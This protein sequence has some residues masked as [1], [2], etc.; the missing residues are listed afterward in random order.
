MW[1]TEKSYIKALSISLI[2][3]FFLFGLLLIEAKQEAAIYSQAKT[4]KKTTL[5]VNEHNKL[6]TKE[7]LVQATTIDN[8]ELSEA[9]T[10]LKEE[11]ANNEKQKQLKQALLEKQAAFARKLRET[12]QKNLKK[13]KME[14][15]KLALAQKKRLIDEKKHLQDL[16]LRKKQEEQKLKKLEEKQQQKILELER[17]AAK[18][19]EDQ[20]HAKRLAQLEMKQAKLKQEALENAKIAT[21]IEK[22][23]ALI[24]DAISRQWILPE[25]IDHDAKSLFRIRLAEDG[26][27]LEVSLLK[28][29]GDPIL[30]R[31][32]QNAIH[33]ASPLPVPQDP[34]M[35]NIFRDIKLTVNPRNVRV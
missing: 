4:Q 29:S 31:S 7:E 33:K 32:A 27:V 5:V 13:L 8:K 26:L 15:K 9:I 6:P 18:V 16:A 12:E 24:T 20:E 34:K 25:N 21:E 30:D 22:Y 17:T 11:R 19:R 28:S 1:E 2:L 23:K 35:F 3:H 14:A 10:K